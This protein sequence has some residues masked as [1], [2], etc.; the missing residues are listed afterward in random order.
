[1][2]KQILIKVKSS[3]CL[4]R[5]VKITVHIVTYY[6]TDATAKREAQTLLLLALK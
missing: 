5:S 4:E 2:L 6:A 1:M 3:S